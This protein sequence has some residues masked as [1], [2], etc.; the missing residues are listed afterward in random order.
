MLDKKIGV[1]GG[2]QLGKMLCQAAAPMG[3]RLHILDSSD[4]VA[5]MVCPQFHEG[6]FRS[7]DDVIEFGRQMDIITVEIEDVNTKALHILEEEGKIVRPSASSLEIIN[8]KGLQRSFFKNA[9][10]PGSSFQLIDSKA[11]LHNSL[12]DKILSFPFVL[13]LRKGGYDGRG[14]FIIKKENDLDALP[15]TRYLIEEQVDILK[16]ISILVARNPQGDISLYSPVDMVF[17]HK[18]NLVDY[19]VFP[20]EMEKNLLEKANNIATQCAEALEIC[21][22]LAIELFITSSGE[23]L[24]NEVA[25]RPHNSGHQT[26][27][28]CVTSQYEQH[29]RG[30]LGLSLGS[31]KVNKPAVMINLLGAPG[32][33]GKPIVQGLEKILNTEGAHLHLY[34]KKQ[35]RPF[36]KMGHI[37]VTA[38]TTEEALEKAMVLKKEVKII[39]EN[40]L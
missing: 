14:V 9:G 33:E 11:D 20:F 39:G 12:D 3:I 34:G 10:I 13:K 30:I 19:L 15:D 31:T 4:E 2:G 27:E 7:Y 35:T 18:A 32:Y 6:S 40:L 5:G 38:D 29:L 25:P 1:L 16:E 8:D 26:I 17:D 28:S 22:M 24:V 23:V 36:R 21:G 37:T